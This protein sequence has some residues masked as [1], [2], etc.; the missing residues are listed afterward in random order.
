MP[1]RSATANASA[2]QPCLSRRTVL[3]RALGAAAATALGRQ[4][5]AAQ[6]CAPEIWDGHVHLAGVTG[7]IEERTDALLQC[8]DRLGIRRLVVFLG[9]LGV[10]DPD[11]A[12]VRQRNDEVLQAIKHAPDRIM[13]FVYLSPKHS[14]ESLDEINRCVRD[15]PMIGVKLW[16]SMRCH[17]PQLDPIVRRASELKAPILQHTFFRRGGNLPGESAPS[18]LAALAA[19]HPDARF[20][21]GHSGADWELGLRAIRTS[22]N[23]WAETGGFD[24]T[25]GLVEMAVRELGAA[26]VIFGSDAG[27]RSFGSQLAKVQ[28]ADL[29]DAERRLVLRD[30]L[31]GLLQPIMAA[32]GMK[33]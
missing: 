26:R 19:R 31:R 25:A 22:P 32:K 27:G 4:A 21:C 8:A 10:H 20:L 15:G 14:E 13:G 16:V 30:N 5:R 33:S 9:A 28:S 18:H 11:P 29:P 7:S 1:P 24:P 12:E 6:G 23:I 17:E 2:A 3:A